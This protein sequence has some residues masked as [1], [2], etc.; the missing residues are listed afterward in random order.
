MKVLQAYY[1]SCRVG[2]SGASGFQYYSYSEGLTDE[3]L[4]E[5][6][7]IGNYIAPMNLPSDPTQEDIEMLFP[8][9]LNYFKLRS[10]KTGVLQSVAL[11]QDYSGRPG[12][13]LSHALILESGEFPF[14]PIRLYKSNSF[15]TNLTDEQWSVE[16]VPAKLPTLDISELEL[17]NNISIDAIQEFLS[18]NGNEDLFTQILNSVIENKESER[19]IVVVDEFNNIPLWIAAITFSFPVNLS[20]EI[21]FSTYTIDPG[22]NTHLVCGTA[23][24][25]T[26]FNLNSEAAY[27]YQY[28]IFNQVAKRYSEVVF[29]SPY[30]E[31]ANTALTISYDRFSRLLDFFDNF[32][33]DSIHKN[34]GLISILYSATE[35]N[36]P[37]DFNWE[38]ILDFALENGTETYLKGF[39][40]RYYTNLEK[41]LYNIQLKDDVVYFGKLLS[42]VKLSRSAED[43]LSAFKLYFERLNIIVFSNEGETMKSYY[44]ELILSTNE[45][46]INSFLVFGDNF[47]KYFFSDEWLQEI[48]NH[49]DGD[50]KAHYMYYIGII[51]QNARLCKYDGDMLFENPIF[52]SILQSF[53]DL[54][55]DNDEHFDYTILNI[56]DTTQFYNILLKISSRISPD[57]LGNILR[58]TDQN[59]ININDLQNVLKRKKD[60]KLL[61]LSASFLI[62]NSSD[63]E[64][65]FWQIVD[66]IK[67]EGGKPESFELL[68]R[69]Y[70]GHKLS[71]K[72]YRNV[73]NLAI[74]IP[75]SNSLLTELVSKLETLYTL[76]EAPRIEDYPFIREMCSFKAKRSIETEPNVFELLNVLINLKEKKITSVLACMQEMKSGFNNI[77]TETLDSF[78]KILFG[79]IVEL[80]SAPKD[81]FFICCFVEG[82]KVKNS[83]F[84]ILEKEITDW[85]EKKKDKSKLVTMVHFYLEWANYQMSMDIRNQYENFVEAVLTKLDD[86]LLDEVEQ[87]VQSKKIPESPGNPHMQEKLFERV[88]EMKGKNSK[89]IFS[90]IF[91]K[92]KK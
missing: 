8:V 39:I 42:F 41:I 5:L 58:K 75:C 29:S 25:G 77:S 21:T 66:T 7:K 6:E 46:I 10:G 50:N 43:F 67:T 15:A 90:N 57:K 71:R 72:E 52:G 51:F 47:S 59:K 61:A 76:K 14:H 92:F 63:K 73:I 86:K 85:T 55:D 45:N 81:Y 56:K 79:Y 27:A 54:L 35:D 13:F 30:S 74:E 53:I 34:I 32:R 11:T 1:T 70:S 64:D 68:I 38:E 78:L 2:Q 49:L 26:R 20:K 36:H 23:G 3:D 69:Q 65:S 82:L 31:V 83:S 12:N 19:R 24:E 88:K 89:N 48:R 84:V 17:N 91:K 40:S 16:H 60:S 9:S 87:T 18:E 22:N 33:Y 4:L 44:L 28:Y 37:Y 80:I 62:E